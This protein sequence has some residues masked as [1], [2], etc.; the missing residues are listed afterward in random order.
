MF[1]MLLF[2]STIFKSVKGFYERKYTQNIN[3][4]SSAQRFGGRPLNGDAICHLVVEKLSPAVTEQTVEFS[5]E[6]PRLTLQ[7]NNNSCSHVH[8]GNL[9]SIVN[10]WC[11][12]FWIER[13]NEYLQKEPNRTRN[14]KTFQFT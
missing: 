5:L 12:F 3:L 14:T 2:Y 4:T 1:S 8:L 9:E 13:G 10:L 7:N 11:V 6:K